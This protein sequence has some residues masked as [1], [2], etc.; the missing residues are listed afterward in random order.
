MKKILLAV[1]VAA[2]AT[3]AIASAASAAPGVTTHTVTVNAATDGVVDL[4]AL[5]SQFTKIVLTHSGENHWSYGDDQ[6]VTSYDAHDRGGS[7]HT[8]W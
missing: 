3:M 5:N 8:A 2:V 7:P 6:H 1:A 4:P